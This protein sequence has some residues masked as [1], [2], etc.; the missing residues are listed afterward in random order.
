VAPTS[1]TCKPGNGKGD[2]NHCHSGPPGADDEDVNGQTVASSKD[3]PSP[4]PLAAAGMI[5]LLALTLPVRR[6]GKTK[7]TDG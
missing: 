7:R 6:L 2:K 4:W 5:V 3:S 1:T